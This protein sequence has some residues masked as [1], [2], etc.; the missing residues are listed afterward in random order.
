MV[1]QEK[2]KKRWCVPYADSCWFFSHVVRLFQK[3][4]FFVLSF[5]SIGVGYCCSVSLQGS[6]QEM[7]FAVWARQLKNEDS[8]FLGLGGGR[9][10]GNISTL[11]DCSKRNA[12]GERAS[13]I[14]F[15]SSPLECSPL[16]TIRSSNSQIKTF[17]EI[18][19]TFF[20]SRLYQPSPFKLQIIFPKRSSAAAAAFVLWGFSPPLSEGGP[21]PLAGP[22][23]LRALECRRPQNSS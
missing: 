15:S 20:P 16:S 1:S 13:V 10:W 17:F 19:S 12:G 6:L 7:S 4:F 11:D 14:F 5:L 23:I 21:P 2:T 22:N 18:H 3:S 8:R 9:L